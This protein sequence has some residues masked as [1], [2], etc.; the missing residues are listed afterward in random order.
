MSHWFVFC[1]LLGFL[2]CLESSIFS[3]N[4]IYYVGF[5][6]ATIVASLILFQGFNTTDATNTITLVAGFVVT[7]LGV[8]LLNMSRG[9]EPAPLDVASYQGHGRRH[10]LLDAGLM[11]PRVSIAG[12]SVSVDNGDAWGVSPSGN[13]PYSATHG[14][15]SSLYRAQ[16]AALQSAFGDEE[17][18]LRT[19][20]DSVGLQLLREEDEDEDEEFE[21][22]ERTKLNSADRRDRA[23]PLQSNTKSPAR[24][25]GNGR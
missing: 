22:H 9:P 23:S 2:F 16:N 17:G 4:P 12:R 25:N 13:G 14:R 5:S 10:S 8:Q 20:G 21:S 1:V 6:T 11:N 3:V 7:F 19:P 18:D 24:T 15:R